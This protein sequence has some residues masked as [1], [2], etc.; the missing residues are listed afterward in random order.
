[1]ATLYTVHGLSRELG[2]GVEILRRC[3]E[4]WEL[5]G[6]RRNGNGAGMAPRFFTEQQARTIRRALVGRRLRR[7]GEPPPWS[8]SS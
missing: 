1:M 3:L 7:R 5:P 6:V 2:I 8:L 4:S